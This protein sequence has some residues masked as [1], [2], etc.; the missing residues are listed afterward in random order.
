[1]NIKAF[2]SNLTLTINGDSNWVFNDNIHFNYHAY[3][4]SKININNVMHRSQLN[5]KHFTYGEILNK[6]PAHS[7]ATLSSNGLIF[8][9]GVITSIGRLSLNPDKVKDFSI[10]IS[11]IR[12][13]LSKKTPADIQFINTPPKKALIDFIEAL[14][15]PKIKIGKVSFSNNENINAYDTV[16]KNAYSILK[17][18]I[19]LQTKSF[20]YFT[21][22]KHGNI[23]INY[24]S[25]QEFE[26][27]E[28]ITLNK[29]AWKNLK[30]TDITLDS[31]IDNY[32]NKL[33]FE[34]ENIINSKPTRESH[35]LGE[36]LNTLVLKNNVAFWDETPEY[37]Y[38]ID[39]DETV[40]QKHNLTITTK[41][42]ANEG[43]EYHFYFS[44]GENELTRNPK[45][46]PKNKII[47]ISYFAKRR[48]AITV[49]N[50]KEI[51]RIQN[52]TNFRGDVYAYDKYNDFSNMEDLYRFAT[53]EL[54]LKSKITSNLTISCEVPFLNI[55]DSVKLIDDQNNENFYICNSYSGSFQGST[56]TLKVKYNLTNSLAADTI[57]NF[58]DS[59]SF[60]DK[61]LYANT[62]LQSK[63]QDSVCEANY[64]IIKG[65]IL[66]SGGNYHKYKYTT[67]AFL[68]YR[69]GMKPQLNIDFFVKAKQE[70]NLKEIIKLTKHIKK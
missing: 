42:K 69:I 32:I 30:I 50:R 9:T 57:L 3:N 28:P 21:S 38:F 59:Q 49:E 20:L 67:K 52:L 47:H 37:N 10:E 15:E 63:Y 12:D 11:D 27:Q 39:M 14:D 58:Y 54:E 70:H 33:R 51:T 16:N 26:A 22:D 56:N 6:L 24:K 8:F 18:I 35:E 61:P 1:M 2:D 66:K 44:P 62:Q 29:Q 7:I 43:Y 34:S 64:E 25:Q 31:N 68:P 36:E 53:H 55:G 19:A 13:W 60:R 46:N 40:R 4:F 65:L 48:S 45:F 23:L 5:G 17:E 41:E